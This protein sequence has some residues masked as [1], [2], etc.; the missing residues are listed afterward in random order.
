M[1]IHASSSRIYKELSGTST[2]SGPMCDVINQ[3]HRRPELEGRA[4]PSSLLARTSS[5]R[6]TN[7]RNK[8]QT[9]G[10]SWFQ[11]FRDQDAQQQYS[12]RHIS[13]LI[14]N[15]VP[16]RTMRACA[17]ACVCVRVYVCYVY[18]TC[19]FTDR[20]ARPWCAV[21]DSSSS[22]PT[23]SS[24]SSSLSSS[25]SSSSRCWRAKFDAACLTSSTSSEPRRDRERER[26]ISRCRRLFRSPSWSALSPLRPRSTSPHRAALAFACVCALTSS[27]GA[28]RVPIRRTWSG[29]VRRPAKPRTRIADLERARLGHRRRQ[30]VPA[31]PPS[32]A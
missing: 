27:T 16:V 15:R 28:A 7:V 2:M 6:K 29:E 5:M 11:H 12:R 23:S 21:V 13:T 9:C 26:K 3:H 10:A 32:P 4:T 14:G 18:F 17:R 20:G 1:A 24:A 19:S 25:S 22:P 8:A 30:T 31:P